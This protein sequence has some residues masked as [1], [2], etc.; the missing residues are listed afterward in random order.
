MW[1]G[2][3]IV[4]AILLG[5][6]VFLAV[7]YSPTAAAFER[8]VADQTKTGETSASLFCEADIAEL[9]VPVQNY[10]RH[11]GYLGTPKMASMTASLRDVD[12]VLSED[13]T[14][15]ID[16]QQFNLVERPD[17]F[18]LISSSIYGLPFEGLDS[19]ANGEG[20]MKG[21]LAKVIPLF[22]Q[23]GEVMNQSC[24]VTW[25]AECLL[26]PNAALQDFVRWRAVDDTHAV[27]AA[28]WAGI[29][30]E[31][32][33]TFSQ[34]GELKS[35]RTGDRVAVD[36]NGNE[37]KADWSAFFLHYHRVNGYLQPKVIQSVWHYEKGD[38]VYFNENESPVD[39]RY[40]AS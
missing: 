2:I 14:I 19:Y 10:F 22:D 31:G 5:V 32:T 40:Q 20:S 37:T 34:T 35:F 27:A 16:Y 9:P 15:K 23:Q 29:A 36:M 38:C 8:I 1:I 25:L 13:K 24:L 11:C 26:V 17:R 7:P 21:R 39:I 33:F 12:F 28:T 4:L 3:I 18:A 6:V 30:V